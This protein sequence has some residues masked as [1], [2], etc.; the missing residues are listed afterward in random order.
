MLDYI[1]ELDHQLLIFINQLG[2]TNWDIFWLTITNA[3]NWIPFFL[4]I[5]FV[6]FKKFSRRE[7][8][9]IL[10][11][12]G[13]T[14]FFTAM[15]TFGTKELVQ[16]FRPLHNKELMPY[17]RIITTEKGYSF[18]SGHTSNSFAICTFLYLVLRS[19]LKWA[20]WVYLWAIPYAFSRMYL[21]VHFPTDVVVG[22][23]V[24]VF[25]AILVFYLGYK[26]K[27]LV[28]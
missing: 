3:W 22:L 15:M 12:F 1:R 28:Q 11:Y 17:L 26:R 8:K 25:T 2:N 10:F 14:F 21:A 4:L 5:L 16:R 13:L 27:V 19:V 18:F 9:W 6:V 7:V 23:F 20:F 24:G